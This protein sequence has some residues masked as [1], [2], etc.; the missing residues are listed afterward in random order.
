MVD[1]VHHQRHDRIEPSQEVAPPLVET[2]DRMA[3]D[4]YMTFL[5]YHSN[6]SFISS[7]GPTR[8]FHPLLLSVPLP[9]LT[10]PFF[11]SGS[12]FLRLLVVEDARAF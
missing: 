12:P 9:R 2:D 3:A 5:E 8:V 6:L 4:Y 10:L 1:L 7:R 11:L